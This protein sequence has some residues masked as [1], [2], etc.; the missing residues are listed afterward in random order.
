MSWGIPRSPKYL[1]PEMSYI[2]EE[3]NQRLIQVSDIFT[4]ETQRLESILKSYPQDQIKSCLKLLRQ[5]KEQVLQAVEQFYQIFEGRIYSQHANMLKK[6]ELENKAHFLFEIILKTQ[7][8]I[9]SLQQILN[10]PERTMEALQLIIGRNFEGGIAK[11]QRDIDDYDELLLR[12][13]VIVEKDNAFLEGLYHQ[14]EGFIHFKEIPLPPQRNTSF[15]SEIKMTR[16]E[17]E[18][19][20]NKNQGVDTLDDVI[21]HFSPLKVG[22]AK[23]TGGKNEQIAKKKEFVEI[24]KGTLEKI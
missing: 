23:S 10:D 2:V 20:W 8:E 9:Y 4:E 12:N 22:G 16:E 5:S 14:L 7:K 17:I 3:T 18:D 19:D 1:S 24:K 13:Q 11:I 15:I 6:E 21:A